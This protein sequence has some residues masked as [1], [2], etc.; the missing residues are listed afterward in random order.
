MT[1]VGTNP[2]VAVALAAAGLALLLLAV[3]T[4]NLA[5]PAGPQGRRATMGV[6]TTTPVGQVP[7]TPRSRTAHA[8]AGTPTESSAV[9][10]RTGGDAPAPGA[11]VAG[12]TATLVGVAAGSPIAVPV[13]PP[14]EWT[15]ALTAGPDR[16]P[17]HP[18]PG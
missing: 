18:L 11:D 3:M 15:A 6:V 1:R 16:A 12:T 8:M 10:P 9:Q 7:L 14:A 13:R 4:A 17:P 5:M 2:R